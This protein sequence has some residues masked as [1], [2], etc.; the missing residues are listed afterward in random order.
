VNF[1]ER[2]WTARFPAAAQLLSCR[3]QGRK[4]SAGAATELKQHRL[5]SGETHDVFHRVT[6]ALNEAGASLRVFI[7]RPRALGFASLAIVKI[8][9]GATVLADTVLMIQTNIEPNRRIKRAMLV[10]AQP[11]QIIIEDLGSLFIREV[12][13]CYS[14]IGD[15]SRHAVNQLPHRRFS[16]AI[17]RISPVRNIAI[18]IF[19]DGNLRRQL[20]PAFW[21]LDVFLLKNHLSAIIGDFCRALFPFDLIKRRDSSVAKHALKSQA[22]VFLLVS[23][24]FLT[25]GG[26][27]GRTK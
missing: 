13:I 25:R 24:G 18:E 16:S 7:L 11:R 15:R 4:I 12:A 22:G 14:P 5:A 21:H 19:R 3:S 23:R 10:R 9:S 6:D 8:I 20:A 27:M 1:Q 2:E 26:A 17:V